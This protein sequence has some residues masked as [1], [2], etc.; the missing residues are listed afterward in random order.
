MGSERCFRNGAGSWVVE[1][2]RLQAL[3]N[4]Y[5]IDDRPSGGPTPAV[6]PTPR[7][8]RAG[9]P[10]TRTMEALSALRKES[11]GAPVTPLAGAPPSSFC[12][13]DSDLHYSWLADDT[14]WERPQTVNRGRRRGN[15]SPQTLRP[16]NHPV[17]ARLEALGRQSGV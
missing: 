14:E 10:G 5:M 3:Q 7:Q 9:P 1:C 4:V 13:H 2:D 6:P 8:G 12:S 11:S 15:A 17:E 16:M